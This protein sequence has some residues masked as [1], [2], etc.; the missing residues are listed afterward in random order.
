MCGRYLVEISEEELNELVTA[1]EKNASAH[2]EQF[3]FIF[4]GGEIF[5]GSIAPVITANKEVRF[6]TWGF[7]NIAVTRSFHI[8]AR[9]ET[10]AASKTFG[11]AMLARRCLIPAS[12]YYEWKTHDKKHK[13]KYKFTLPNQAPMYMAGIYSID[14]Q[15]AVLTRAAV[16]DILEIH[17]RMP[18]I[19]PKSL[20]E[21]WLNE[22]SDVLKEAIAELQF[23]PVPASNKQ[24][25]QIDLFNMVK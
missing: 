15:F 25:K 8:N 20:T 3:S 5:P 7:P 11:G 12:G 13:T 2:S 14:G 23:A 19:L 10:A 18:V 24:P 17:D 9:S 16:P 22:S 1:A 6:M 21:T 4:K